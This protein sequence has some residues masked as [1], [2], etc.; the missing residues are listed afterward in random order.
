M[1]YPNTP[2]IILK[3]L[4]Q[5]LR[6]TYSGNG[7]LLLTHACG[8]DNPSSGGVSYLTSPQGLGNVPVPA[9][10]K[11]KSQIV[12]DS[13]PTDSLAIIVPLNMPDTGHNLIFA[14][15]PL[16]MHVHATS[17]LHPEPTL[18][19]GV[20]PS[21][22]LGENVRLEANVSIAANV[23]V[24]DNVTIGEGTILHA[25][26]VLMSGVILGKQCMLYPNVVVREECQIGNRVLIQPG[27]IIGSDGHG[28]FQ[29]DGVNQKIPQ[30]GNV[31]L[32]DDVEI[33]ACT[34]VDRARFHT[35]LISKGSKIDNQVQ[36]AHNVEIGEQ[37]LI[38]AQ[39]AIGGSSKL[40]HHLILGG[41]SGVRDHVTVGNHVTA[42]ARAVI[43]AKTQDNE[44]LGGMPSRPVNQWRQTQAFIQR[45]KELFERVRQLEKKQNKN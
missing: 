39:T 35:T 24:Y 1:S 8:I 6:L 42:V 28:Y 14:E 27:A 17:L 37:A 36:I 12:L 33:G 7:D 5:E 22:I 38:S 16:A 26:V 23:V 20:H 19:D 43:T 9:G 21:A 13:I 10:M 30:V 29:R 41:Q 15:D 40:G 3:N 11:K 44:V 18:K 2:G 25:G 31:I 32:E 45:L 34:T 4:C